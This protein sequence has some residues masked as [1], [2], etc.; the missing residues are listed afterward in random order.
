M[1]EYYQMGIVIAAAFIIAVI[2][3]PVVIP[4]LRKIKAGQSIR[5]DGPK[6]HLVKAGTP[7]MGGFMIIISVTITC[8]LFGGGLNSDMAMLLISFYA[9]AAIGF[10]DDF[11]KVCKHRN[12]G[13]TAKQKFALQIVIAVI[14]AVYQAK[15]S[16]FGTTIYVPFSKIYIDLG[17]L[18]IPFVAFVVVAMVNAVNLTDG[19]DGLAGGVTFLVA[20]F[21]AVVG[22]GLGYTSAVYFIGAIAGGCLGFLVFNKY[23]AKV[24]MGDTGSLALGGAL[25]AAAILMNI[26]LILPIAGGIFVMEALSVI[27]QVISFKTTGRRVFRMAPLHHHFEIGGWKETKVVI[28][29]WSVT[30]LLCLISLFAF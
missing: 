7:T 29:F 18:Y 20:L 3:G 19:L 25:S 6:S 4:I 28:V 12:L 1:A 14:L 9:F 21:L 15:V 2:S 10:V 17:M 23:P 30:L 24:F 27:I 8:L 22:H 11:V 16:E 5:E 26:E 13:L